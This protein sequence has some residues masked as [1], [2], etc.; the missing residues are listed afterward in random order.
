LEKTGFDLLEHD[1]S[2]PGDLCASTRHP[3]HKGLEDSQ[4][5]QWKTITDFYKWC[6]GQGIYLNVPD[7]YFLSGSNKTGMGYRETNWS[8]PRDRQI[9]LGRQNIYDGTWEKTPSMG[10]MFVPLVEYQ[11]G[12]AAATLEPL[13]EHLEA[14]EAHL[15]QNFGSGVQ[16]CYRGMRLYDTELTKAVVKRWVDFYRKYREILDSDIIH[17][18]RPDG[19]GIDGILHVNP[20]T[21]PRGLAVLCNPTDREVQTTV[22]L[23]LYYTGLTDVAL[24]REQEGPA[25]SYRID[26]NYK[27]A[28]PLRISAHGL[29]WFAIE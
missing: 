17:L 21:K 19:A 28:L 23:P 13:S 12:G 29:T 11:G 27:I 26:R 3:G 25:L 4:W 9:I 1:G 16:A 18:R 10:W 20:K 14:Y 22:E 6:R 7:W 8:L 15:A 2:Y 5:T 24:V